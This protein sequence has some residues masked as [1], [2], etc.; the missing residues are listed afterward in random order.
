MKEHVGIQSVGDIAGTTEHFARAPKVMKLRY[1]KYIAPIL[2]AF[3]EPHGH[4]RE[5]R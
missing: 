3:N 2:Q 4:V 5:T 1:Y